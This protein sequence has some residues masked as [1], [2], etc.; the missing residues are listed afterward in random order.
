MKVLDGPFIKWAEKDL[1]D[2][3]LVFLANWEW[4]FRNM[5]NSVRPINSSRP[6]LSHDHFFTT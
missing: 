3:G 6:S 5:T 1:E 4:G 2:A